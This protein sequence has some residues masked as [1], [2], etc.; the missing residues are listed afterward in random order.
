[1]RRWATTI[2]LV[3]LSAA[4]PGAQ[5]QMPNPK[6]MSGMLRP[7][8]AVPVGTITVRVIRGTFDKNLVGQPVEFTIDGEKRTVNTDAAGRAEVSNLRKGARVRAVTIVDGERIESEEAVVSG[9]AGL[10]VLLVATDTSAPAAPAAPAA[11]RGTVVFGESSRVIA[12][13]SDERLNIYYALDIVNAA[14]NPV[15]LGGPLIVELP[16]EARGATVLQGSSKQATAKGP[17]V[18][19]T[20]P[21]APG[22]T[23]VQIGYELPYGGP[24]ARLHQVWPAPLAVLT[25]Y[26]LR[27]GDVDA[28][29][30]QFA[31][32]QEAVE[33]GQPII[34]ASGP[35][36][37]AGNALTV[38]FSGLPHHARWPRYITLGLAGAIMSA[39][40][41]AAVFARP[42]RRGDA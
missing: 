6:A 4:G 26:V 5:P 11:E 18:I 42:R 14:S 41:W 13:L 15:D 10:R 38:D 12:E 9:G 36:I 7:D 3:L 1:V 33:Q 31:S 40:L 19:V 39:G 25:M 8:N 2:A 34:F 28:S 20:G 17:R 29:S 23:L 37:P 30:P 21:F 27:L 22:S 35:P 16:R 24:T 32:K